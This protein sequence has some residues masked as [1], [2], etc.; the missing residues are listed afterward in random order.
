MKIISNPSVKKSSFFVLLTFNKKT[1]LPE[2]S[3]DVNQNMKEL[4]IEQATYSFGLSFSK[5]FS[6]HR[7]LEKGFVFQ[8]SQGQSYQ[9]VRTHILE[10]NQE[11]IDGTEAD[12]YFVVMTLE[13]QS[14]GAPEG[15]S[16]AESFDSSLSLGI[17]ADFEK[18][19]FFRFASYFEG[20]E[21]AGIF[22]QYS[23]DYPSI[24]ILASEKRHSSGD[25]IYSLNEVA[26]RAFPFYWAFY[27]YAYMLFLRVDRAQVDMDVR[28]DSDY[29]DHWVQSL[30]QQRKRI[31]N[32]NRYFLTPDRT[33]NLE[34]RKL[35]THLSEKYQFEK[36][37]NRIK[38]VQENLEIYFES[39]HQINQ[40]KK[41]RTISASVMALT[42][43]GLPFGL[44]GLVFDSSSESLLISNPSEI[45]TN[46]SLLTW[47]SIALL[48]PALL[49]AIIIG[50]NRV[51]ALKEVLTVSSGEESVRKNSKKENSSDRQKKVA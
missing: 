3:L 25:L 41:G 13:K 16:A 31:I 29:R 38:D 7:I 45:F 37:M 28:A 6:S 11:K 33:Q 17:S 4:A 34:I 10:S 42:F 47:I 21:L 9:V 27:Y 2:A 15:P 24:R 48:S 40:E 49:A 50:F 30:M 43:L 26:V 44:M 36:R 22:K 14:E 5:V 1:D 39:I 46:T 12:D 8:D 32:I 20:T 51:K 18:K 35:L 23:C 19:K